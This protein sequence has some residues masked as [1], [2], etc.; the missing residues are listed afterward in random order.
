MKKTTKRL[1]VW[2]ITVA[3]I[4]LIPF[5]TNM[6]WT[7]SDFVFAGVLLFGSAFVYEMLTKDLVDSRRRKI[8]GLVVLGILGFIWVGAATG[9]EGVPNHPVVKAIKSIVNK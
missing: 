1:M 9:F 5:L 3:V 2:A 4:L 6:P 7:G 8:T